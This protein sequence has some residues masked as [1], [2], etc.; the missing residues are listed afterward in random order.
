MNT[1]NN[2]PLSWVPYNPRQRTVN[3]PLRIAE[4]NDDLNENSQ[5][6]SIA[7]DDSDNESED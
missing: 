5:D 7:D 4:A 6:C 3:G 2:K 1:E